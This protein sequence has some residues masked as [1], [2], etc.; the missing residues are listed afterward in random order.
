[1]ENPLPNKIYY[2]EFTLPSDSNFRLDLLY[3]RMEN[4]KASNEEK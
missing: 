1:M 4:L 3:K 2:P